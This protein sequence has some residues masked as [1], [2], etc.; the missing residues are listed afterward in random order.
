[1][2]Y[3]LWLGMYDLLATHIGTDSRPL[4]PVRLCSPLADKLIA[5]DTYAHLLDGQSGKHVQCI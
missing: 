3:F 1:M 2:T 5:K 4:C